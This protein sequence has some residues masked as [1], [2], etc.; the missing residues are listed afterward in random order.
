M[1]SSHI[2]INDDD[3]MM[4]RPTS[5]EASCYWGKGTKWCISATEAANYFAQYTNEGKSFYFLFSKHKDNFAADDWE[6]NK[7]LALVFLNDGTFEEAYDASDQ[8]MDEAEVKQIVAVNLLGNQVSDAYQEYTRYYNMEKLKAE[9]PTAYTI[10]IDRMK[11]DG[12]TPKDDVDDW[13]SNMVVNMWYE[14][15]ATAQQDTQDN[16]AG[17]SEA[18]FHEII[19]NASLVH[20]DVSVDEYD[21]G[22]W[23]WSASV[24]FDF[25]A[26]EWGDKALDEH[27]LE[28]EINTVL[29]SNY[30]YADEVEVY[31]NQVSVSFSTEDSG[32]GESDIDRFSSFVGGLEESDA[33]YDEAREELI[34][35]FIDEG[36][37]DIS[38]SPYGQLRSKAKT[39]EYEH[40]EVDTSEGTVSYYARMELKIPEIGE[41]VQSLTR[42]MSSGADERGRVDVQ[43]DYSHA[44]ANLITEFD[45]VFKPTGPEGFTF[46][47]NMLLDALSKHFLEA[48]NQAMRQLNLP[49]IP[50]AEIRQLITPSK[51]KISWAVLNTAEKQVEALLGIAL[52]RDDEP[53]QMKALGEF[54]D[55]FDKNY[56]DFEQIVSSVMV[57]AL[58][59]AAEEV[60]IKMRPQTQVA[61]AIAE[62]IK[63]YNPRPHKRKRIKII[64]RR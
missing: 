24:A 45:R 12:L 49:G 9:A 47:T 35:M 23:G 17:P 51:F 1:Q 43:S 21:V 42:G 18:D 38:T 57:K 34:D 28:D 50:A 33:K 29:D 6:S 31:Q 32:Y 61:H 56:D 3:F 37:L 22:T 62:N 19:E 4:V 55:Y 41:V 60:A 2:L 16:P 30:I 15:E 10:L 63:K 44:L 25:E 40:F 26:L 53:A 48:Q 11:A 59:S 8:N 5:A 36:A 20:I 64:I 27:E 52:K 39:Q 46:A 58:W 14:I 54:L 13:W 7:K